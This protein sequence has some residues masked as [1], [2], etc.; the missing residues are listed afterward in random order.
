MHV[1]L[2][3]STAVRNL[4]PKIFISKGEWNSYAN[5]FVQKA[6]KSGLRWRGDWY[7]SD[8]V[9][10]DDSLNVYDYSQWESLYYDLQNSC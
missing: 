8:A 5:C 4:L 3:F 1:F 7:P 2:F 10:M 6:K 9:H